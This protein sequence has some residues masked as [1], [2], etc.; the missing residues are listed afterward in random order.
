MSVLPICREV[1][2]HFSAFEVQLE[3]SVGVCK[4]KMDI[5]SGERSRWEGMEI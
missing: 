1:R 3:A 5:L 4:V 2:G